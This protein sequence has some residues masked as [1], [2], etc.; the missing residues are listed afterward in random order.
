MTLL[1]M[2]AYNHS[3]N[4]ERGRS[5]RLIFQA[6]L[7]DVKNVISHLSFS[8]FLCRLCCD[9]NPENLPA[10]SMF[11]DGT[12]AWTENDGGLDFGQYTSYMF[13]ECDN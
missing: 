3:F 13:G 9:G 11:V 4:L 12:E 6:L 8:H 1:V 2:G 5:V 7:V 10:Y